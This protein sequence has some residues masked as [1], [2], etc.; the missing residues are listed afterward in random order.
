VLVIGGKLLF[1]FENLTPC[2]NDKKF[3][4]SAVQ[5][6][7]NMAAGYIEMMC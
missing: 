6:L 3:E 1:F 5:T 7:A 4:V 2:H